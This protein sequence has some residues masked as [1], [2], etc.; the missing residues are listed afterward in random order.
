M[1]TFGAVGSKVQFEFCRQ[2]WLWRIT[3]YH[4]NRSSNPIQLREPGADEMDC[5]TQRVLRHRD[6]LIHLDIFNGTFILQ[7]FRSKSR[8]SRARSRPPTL[9]SRTPKF[10][11]VN[12][13][14]TLH[15]PY[16]DLSREFEAN[17][18]FFGIQYRSES[19]LWFTERNKK[20][21]REFEP[22]KWQRF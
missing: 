5:T 20:E 14:R 7:K 17:I 11:Q 15:R 10:F 6:V 3:W 18:E 16:V 4:E 13:V 9:K 2:K 8:Y 21:V 1:L 22:V 12:T 19:K